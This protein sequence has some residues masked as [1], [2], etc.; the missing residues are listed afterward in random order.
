MERR[1][2]NVRVHLRLTW[3]VRRKAIECIA[4]RGAGAPS[5]PRRTLRPGEI[6]IPHFGE[7][8]VPSAVQ[9]S[10][11]TGG[12]VFAQRGELAAPHDSAQL[13]CLLGFRDSLAIET[14]PEKP[15]SAWDRKAD[16]TIVIDET[17]GTCA[18]K[19]VVHYAIAEVKDDTVY[20][21]KNY[22]LKAEPDVKGIT[23]AKLTGCGELAFDLK[24][25]MFRASD[26]T[27]SLVLARD[28][29]KAAIPQCAS[30][31]AFNKEE[32]AAHV[33]KTRKERETAEK[34][35]A[36][37]RNKLRE[38]I[39]KRRKEAEARTAAAA[40]GGKPK[41][42]AAETR[43][44]VLKDLRAAETNLAAAK[45][46]AQR[47]A[48]CLPGDNADEISAALVQAMKDS[49]EWGSGVFLE[50]LDVWG[51]SNCEKALI[52]ASKS[53]LF[54]IKGKAI[55]ILT[56]K[57][58]D[59]T[60]I[61]AMAELFKTDHGA[62][63]DAMR[64][65]GPAAEKATI[66]F[67]V[68][69]DFWSR[70]DAVAALRDIG[71]QRSLRALKR[72]L[73]KYAPRNNPLETNPFNDAI[74]AIE[75]RLADQD[76]GASAK[77]GQPKVRLWEDATGSFNVEATLIGVKDDKVTLKK[78]DGKEITVPLS[79]LAE[80]DRAYVKEYKEELSKPKPVNPFE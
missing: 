48:H 20:I 7:T 59:E 12:I 44:Q 63:A 32:M 14:L 62:A 43:A 5:A 47:L 29:L 6:F 19:E 57:F 64:K 58:K 33:E 65:I 53:G 3:A 9:P 79:K 71:G 56:K 73:K 10:G 69:T 76:D 41:P 77:P 11:G 21:T 61:N 30:Y 68:T 39:E 13:P 55:E 25:G 18:A 1:V 40:D 37:M 70:N 72:E 22:S 75:K 67:I 35:A 17:G 74:A 26:M 80:E 51:T 66:P 78:K 52:K 42:L 36:E 4:A 38:M 8:A 50:A 45:E 28:N 24:L 15:A 2:V 31:R 23:R 34:S 46:A 49:D 27:Y 16:R 54:F 60:V